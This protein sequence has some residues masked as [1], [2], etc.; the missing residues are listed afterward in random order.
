MDMH[1][2][3]ECTT[4]SYRQPCAAE[5]GASKIFFR[6]PRFKLAAQGAQES[7]LYEG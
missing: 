7:S 4:R 6:C 3:M 2:I 1:E 5:C